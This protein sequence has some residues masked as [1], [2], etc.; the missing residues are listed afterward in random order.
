MRLL[1]NID[2]SDTLNPIELATIFNEAIADM[3][4]LL[5]SSLQRFQKTQV[6][7][8]FCFFFYFILF[9]FILCC[10]CVCLST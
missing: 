7:F 3:I 10:V 2:K 6:Y 1:K 5:D 8:I 9:I 4:V